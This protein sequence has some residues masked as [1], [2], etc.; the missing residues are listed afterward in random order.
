MVVYPDEQQ[1]LYPGTQRVEVREGEHKRGIDFGVHKK[2][3]Q[4]GSIEGLIYE[5][6]DGDGLMGDDE[7]PLE[8]ALSDGKGW[9][10][11]LDA[12]LN[13]LRDDGE[14]FAATEMDGSYKI[15]P[16]DCCVALTVALELT[17]EQEQAWEV[18]SP[19]GAVYT[20]ELESGGTDTHA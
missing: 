4:P 15:A 8:H 11:Y 17:D 5:D 13:G 19:V 1:Q 18:T 16:A 20:M 12:N 2:G 14:A 10:V 6:E 9:V 7:S 3:P